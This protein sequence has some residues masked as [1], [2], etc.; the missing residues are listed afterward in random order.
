MNKQ[1]IQNA[2][3]VVDSFRGKLFYTFNDSGT[4]PIVLKVV[5][6]GSNEVRCYRIVT[7]TS[8]YSGYYDYTIDDLFDK[9]HTSVE[10]MLVARDAH[11]LDYFEK[12]KDMFAQVTL[13]ANHEEII[14]SRFI[15][16]IAIREQ[17]A[18]KIK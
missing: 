17:L 15:E 14:R 12:H 9:Y 11:R 13:D 10:D 8:E 2:V 6:V 7:P 18:A 3:K 1:I 16:D 4:N 5:H